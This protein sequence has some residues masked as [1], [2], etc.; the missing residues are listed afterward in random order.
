MF[1]DEPEDYVKLGLRWIAIFWVGFVA[2]L[3]ILFLAHQA[4]IALGLA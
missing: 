4:C 1:G 2:L 3:A